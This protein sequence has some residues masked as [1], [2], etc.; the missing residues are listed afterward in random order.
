[1]GLA[2]LQEQVLEELVISQEQMLEVLL[3]VL[4]VSQVQIL[5]R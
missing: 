1:L 5:E 4:V 2:I 3:L